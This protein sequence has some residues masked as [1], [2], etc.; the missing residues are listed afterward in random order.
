MIRCFALLVMFACSGF[1]LRA[2]ESLPQFRDLAYNDHPR[3]RLDIYLPATDPP[4]P[5]VVL[6]HGGGFRFGDKRIHFEM[7]RYLVAQGYAVV[8][9]NYR[10][11]PEYSHPAPVEDVFC[12][13]AWVG[14]HGAGFDLNTERIAA[15]GESAGGYL[16]LALGMVDAPPLDDCP[17]TQPPPVRAVIA[18]YPITGLAFE[19]Y[20]P[21]TALFLYS[22]AGVAVGAGTQLD[23]H[24][25]ATISPT[26]WI[27]STE[28]PILLIHGA[29]DGVVPVNDTIRMADALTAAGHQPEVLLIADAN[30]AFIDRLNRPDGRAAAQT[31]TAFLRDHLRD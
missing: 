30:H 8:A 3:Q 21:L 16:A 6:I 14:N 26:R 27:D 13:L 22:Y 10:L 7:A 24:W 28:P 9:P 29:D 17:Q 31:V 15:L 19:D 23:E 1:S 18:Y 25:N 12:A 11:T 2:Q 20:S 4:H 5:T